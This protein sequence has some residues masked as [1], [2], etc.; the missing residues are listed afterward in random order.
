M[1]SKLQERLARLGPI[2]DARPQRSGSAVDIV[3]RRASGQ[4]RFAPVTAISTLAGAGLSLLKAKRAIE[5][6]PANG[7]IAVTLLAVMDIVRLARDMRACGI[8]VAIFASGAVD[9]RA[10]RVSLGL[11]QEQFALRFNLGLDNVQRWEQGQRVPDRVAS[12]YLR[13]IANDPAAAANA[14]EREPA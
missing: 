4:R 5:A 9:V 10:L 14:Q 1:N 2:R 13:V 11:T 3:L 12:N 7:E 8:D 6:L